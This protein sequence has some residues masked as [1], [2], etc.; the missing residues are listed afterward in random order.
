M[1]WLWQPGEIRESGVPSS[2]VPLPRKRVA[3]GEY[4]GKK[5]PEMIQRLETLSTGNVAYSDKVGKLTLFIE[6]YLF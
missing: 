5:A 1:L 6:C 4:P 2:S 3:H